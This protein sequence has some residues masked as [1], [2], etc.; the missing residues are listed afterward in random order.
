MDTVWVALLV[1]VIGPL[2][3]SWLNGRQQQSKL[4]AEHKQRMAD[5]VQDYARQDAVADRLL[6]RQNAVASQAAAA[7]ELLLAAQQES[8]RRTDEVAR[9]AAE[10]AQSTDTQLKI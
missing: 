4:A 10:N 8:I 1:A 7:A 5:K 2:L 3:L 6:A 9:L